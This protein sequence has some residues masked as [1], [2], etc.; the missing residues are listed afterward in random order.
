M[1]ALVLGEQKTLTRANC[2][3]VPISVAEADGGVAAMQRYSPVATSVFGACDLSDI[4]VCCGGLDCV[5]SLGGGSSLPHSLSQTA[6]ED[7]TAFLLNF[8]FHHVHLTLPHR[9]TATD[10]VHS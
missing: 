8:G 9:Q 5:Q 10:I 6:N 1:T 4:R 7:E 2:L 3:N